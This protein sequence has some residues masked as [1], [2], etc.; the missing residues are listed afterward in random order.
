[1]VEIAPEMR[2]DLRVTT[3]P[4]TVRAAGD[5]VSALGELRV[6]ED[7]Y[8][9]V[10]TPM[11]ARVV[12]V[13]AG[14]GE[15]VSAGQPLIE[16]QS[17]EL[18]KARGDYLIAKA[19]ADL[20]Q[21]ALA[22]K[23]GLF[24]EHIVPKR[25]L[26]EAEAEAAAAAAGLRAAHATLQAMGV[27][28]D[29]GAAGEA[30][31]SRLVLRAPIAGTVLERNAVPGQAIEP[32]RP[33][34]R[35]ADLSRLWLMAQAFE[36]DALRVQVGG[37]AHVTFPAL[38]GQTFSGT[39]RLVASQV[40]PSSRTIP[41]RVEVQ[42]PDG[43]LRPGMSATVWLPFEA[44]AGNVVTVPA[45][46]LQ[47]LREGWCVFVPRGEGRFEIRQVGRGR[48]LGS[49]VE[50]VGGLQPGEAVVVD[51]AFLLKAEAEKARGGVP[52]EE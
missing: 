3:A 27:P 21:R 4:A 16:L 18:G 7:V 8:T 34:F 19:R 13:L 17:V 39:V 28:A 41:I 32:A 24:A 52:A 11:V 36:R 38:P 31:P 43:V 48:E 20:A 12:K 2:R 47:R 42:N 5:G 44:A 14:P 46:A 23:Q 6:D 49:D 26:Q 22:R 45:P 10:G 25:E 1:M 9:E 37:A 50:V 40:D 29:D 35:I 15:Q 51:G 33:L 30:D